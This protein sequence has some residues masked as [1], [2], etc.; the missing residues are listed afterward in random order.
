MASR[1]RRSVRP[2]ALVAAV[3][4]ASALALPGC[5]HVRH[6]HHHHHHGG[7]GHACGCAHGP[8]G[9]KHGGDA[10]K[11]GACHGEG[12]DPRRLPEGHPPVA[13]QGAPKPGGEAE[14]A[15]A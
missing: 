6:T 9:A 4:A 1:S 3:L 15:G 10:G 5:L 12:H 14:P 13:P 2:G 11:G 7:G 8:H